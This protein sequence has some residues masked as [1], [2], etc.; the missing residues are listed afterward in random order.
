MIDL[1]EIKKVIKE[2][3]MTYREIAK[4]LKMPLSK[5][6][7]ILNGNQKMY[8]NDYLSM[9]KL[10]GVSINFFVIKTKR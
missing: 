6:S 1:I 9:C 10:L 3:G 8:I 5:L 4:E 7:K 2:K